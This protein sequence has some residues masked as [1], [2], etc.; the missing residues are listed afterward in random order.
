V[1]ANIV[2]TTFDSAAVGIVLWDL[3]G[4]FLL[5]NR[6]LCDTLGYDQEELL[7]KTL[8]KSP[9]DDLAKAAGIERRVLDGN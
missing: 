1:S 8:Q 6:A 7:R 5:A 2:Q 3:T 9:P 4:R